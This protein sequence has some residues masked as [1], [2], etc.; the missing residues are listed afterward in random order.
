MKR[1][2]CDSCGI[3]KKALNRVDVPCHL[4]SLAGKCGYV[5]EDMNSVSG[6]TETLELCNKCKNI[7]YGAMLKALGLPKEKK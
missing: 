6:R 3:E 4:N 2:F 5:D 1:Y 7:G